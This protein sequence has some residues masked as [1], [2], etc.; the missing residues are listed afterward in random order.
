M[1]TAQILDRIKSTE[2]PLKKQLLTV[3]LITKLLEEM[4]KSPPVI[5]R[6]CALS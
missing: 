5:I 2:S 4:G 3:A 1:K 6:G